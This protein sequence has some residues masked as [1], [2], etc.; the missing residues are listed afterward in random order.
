[1]EEGIF[2]HVLAKVKANKEAKDQGKITSIFPETLERLSEF[3]PGWERGTYNIISASSGVGKTKLTKFL[4]VTSIYQF[5][6]KYPIRTKI[7]YFALEE[8]KDE[9]W[10]SVVSTLLHEKYGISMHNSELKSLGKFHLSEDVLQKIESCRADIEDMEKYIDVIDHVSNPFGIYKHVREYFEDPEVG[11]YIKE[12]RNGETYIVGYKHNDPDFYPFVVTDHVSLLLP[13]KASTLH[14]AMSLFSKEYCLKGFC[15]RFKC[16]VINVQ[17]QAAETERQ[18]FHNGETIEQK[19]EPS[20]NGLADNKTT[21]RE[22]DLVLGLFA[23]ARYNLKK[24]RGYDITKLGD[25]V[26]FLKFLKDRNYG[27]ANA[28]VPLYF[29]GAANVFKELPK[30]DVINYEDYA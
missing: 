18:E 23:P 25:K 10:L 11:E 3:F 5:I 13:E 4:I 15:K 12:I 14:E 26:R 19:L 7:F 21:Q 9:F 24:Y 29:N 6:K 30:P 16:V 17:Q 22:A 28:Y 27:L 2:D 8:S 1:M 20:L